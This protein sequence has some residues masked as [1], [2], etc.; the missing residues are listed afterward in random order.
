MLEAGMTMKIDAVETRMERLEEF[1]QSFVSEFRQ[2]L[3]A[4]MAKHLGHVLTKKH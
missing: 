2:L 3:R 4:E 1:V